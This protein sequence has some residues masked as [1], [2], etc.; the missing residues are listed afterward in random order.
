[1]STNTVEHCIIGLDAHPDTCS[2]AGLY[3][4]DAGTAKVKWIDHPIRVERIEQWATKRVGP[5]DTVVI[6]ASGNTFELAKRLQKLGCHVVVLESQRV[7]Q[8]GKAYCN[9][10]KISAV[11]IARVFLSGLAVIVWKPDE[12]T[13]Q[14]R[15]LFRQYKCSVTDATR[16]RNRISSWLTGHGMKRP[17][18]LRMTL[19]SGREWV[20]THGEWS[21]MQ[22][23]LIEQMF[24]QL[25][26][27]HRLRKQLRRIIA[28]EV[29]RDPALLQLVRLFGVA[30]IT[31]F[32]LGAFIGDVHRFRSPKQLVAYIGLNPRVN[33]S[34]KGGHIGSL[35]HHG[36]KELRALLVESAQNLLRYDNPLKK[37]GWKLLIAKGRNVAAVAMARKLAVSCWYL[38]M[39]RFT[40]LEQPGPTLRTKITKIVAVIGK[41]TVVSLGYSKC[42]DFE[43]YL[44][45]QIIVS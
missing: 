45:Q 30:E 33:L 39:G 44:L 36:R 43:E 27:T 22:R 9:T 28:L 7:G 13:R 26:A 11:K 38:M 41:K 25:L 23:L 31:A 18:G 1:M 6:E 17:K 24:D 42:V 8:V 4:A 16:Q 14:R 32:A 20:M 10:D 3:G 35:G 19:P 37:W 34:G 29:V 40:P 12:Q 21:P 5:H 15:E 2:A